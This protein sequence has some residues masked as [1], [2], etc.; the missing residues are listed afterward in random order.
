M[1]NDE[2]SVE[3]SRVKPNKVLCRIMFFTDGVAVD[4]YGRMSIE[5]VSHA[6]GIFKRIVRNLPIA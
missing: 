5:P 3:E 2:H 4:S 6:L 1:H